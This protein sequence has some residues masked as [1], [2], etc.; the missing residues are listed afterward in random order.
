MMIIVTIA[1]LLGMACGMRF[2][3]VVFILVMVVALALAAAL[4]LA[5][6][7]S[8]EAGALL[9]VAAC[10]VALQLGYVCGLLVRSRRQ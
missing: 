9:H 3:I 7:T 2:G 10:A 8:I 5:D 6:Q 1:L 4:A